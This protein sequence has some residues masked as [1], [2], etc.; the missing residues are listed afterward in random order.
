VW[1]LI[2]NSEPGARKTDKVI[3]NIFSSLKGAQV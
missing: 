2:R 3:F 1:I